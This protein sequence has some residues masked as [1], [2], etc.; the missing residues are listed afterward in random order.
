MPD[1]LLI[2]KK[3]L[4]YLDALTYVT[5]RSF[6]NTD[7]GYGYPSYEKIMELSGLGRT[8]LSE[9]IKRLETAKFLKITHSKAKGTCNQYHFD[10]LDHFERIPYEFFEIKELT[11]YQKAMFLCLRQFFIHGKL[12]CADS[13]TTIAKWLGVSYK[14]VRSNYNA[15][16]AKGYIKEKHGPA[17]H[18]S[19]GYVTK[20]FTDKIDW[21]Y[22]YTNRFRKPITQ[23]IKLKIS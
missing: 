23:L 14:Q 17:H 5:I 22:E 4:K 1:F 21:N 8:F 6:Y 18:N 2:N 3:K 15:L 20:I 10:K 19:K 9:S 7:D 11:V 12:Q 16:L 13:I